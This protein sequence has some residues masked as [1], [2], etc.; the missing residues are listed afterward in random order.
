MI[1]LSRLKL[2]GIKQELKYIKD[3]K[4]TYLGTFYPFKIFADKGLEEVKFDTVT[5]FYGGNGS[6]KSTLINILARKMNAIRFSEFN[7]SPL[8]DTYTNM[9]YIE[10]YR[11]P[12]YSC[13]LTSDDVFDYVLNAR[14]VN[15]RLGERRSEVVDNYFKVHEEYRRDP[16][17][18]Q[19]KGIDD[20]ER[21]R[22]V[23][24]I[25]SPKKSMSSLVRKKVVERDVNLGSNGETAIQYF[26]DRIDN[27]GVY[28]LDEPENSLSIEFQMQLVEYILATARATGT[29][30]V[31]ATHSPIFL[32]IKNARIYNLDAYPV[33]CCEW[34]ELPNV[35]KYYDF[36]MEHREEF[37]RA[38]LSDGQRGETDNEEKI[39]R[40]IDKSS[41][42]WQPLKDVIVTLDE[43]VGLSKK[44]QVLIYITLDTEEK[45]ARWFN[46]VSSKC[47]HGDCIAATEVQ[48][49]RAAVKIGKG[50]EPD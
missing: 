15:E 22:E 12:R 24:H 27:P 8:F 43:M 7:D 6:G 11:I 44:N 40:G 5:I 31:I 47:Y 41:P 16:S 23:S 42:Y 49:V 50:K 20:L 35:R 17:I 32:S 21:W 36:F 46:W 4:R 18:R 25:L 38:A 48:I 13:V 29:Q 30:F 28:F 10:H 14:T 33:E 39:T 34:T 45:I 1:Y 26:V 9:C 19:L 2:P 37:E 3:E